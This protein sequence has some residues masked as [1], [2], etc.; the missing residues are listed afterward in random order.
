MNSNKDIW[1]TKEKLKS[2]RDDF[3][4]ENFMHTMIC[5]IMNSMQYFKKHHFLEG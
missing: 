3:E 4:E 5:T 2:M 1:K